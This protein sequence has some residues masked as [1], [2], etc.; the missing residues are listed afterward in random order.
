MLNL[1]LS[2]TLKISIKRECT[3]GDFQI[4]FVIAKA[5][6]VSLLYQPLTYDI[7]ISF[8]VFTNIEFLE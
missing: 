1:L 2:I 6:H 4:S 3:I 7:K 8:I 5:G